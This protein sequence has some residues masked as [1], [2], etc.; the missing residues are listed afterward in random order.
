MSENGSSERVRE[1]TV[2]SHRV[3]E[4]K[5]NIVLGM[6]E[7]PG[8]DEQMMDAIFK[9]VTRDM[10]VHDGQVLILLS[11]PLAS[12]N[13]KPQSASYNE[14]LFFQ[15]FDIFFEPCYIVC[16]SFRKPSQAKE[17]L[18]AIGWQSTKELCYVGIVTTAR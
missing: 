12:G 14:A 8:D 2:R 10:E 6:Y 7:H 5:R 3:E 13:R 9:G 17:S 16:S 4:A 11:D 15:E 1:E 18:R